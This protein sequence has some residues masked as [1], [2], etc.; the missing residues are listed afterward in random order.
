MWAKA[1]REGFLEE[2]MKGGWSCDGQ[3][4]G[5]SGLRVSFSFLVRKVRLAALL[6]SEG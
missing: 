1:V 3:K 2:N 4:A 6:R 5:Q